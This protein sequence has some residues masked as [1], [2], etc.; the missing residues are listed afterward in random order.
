MVEC[1]KYGHIPMGAQEINLERDF[2]GLLYSK[3]EGLDAIGKAR[4]YKETYA[5]S[6]RVR[7][8]I[9]TLPT[10]EPTKVTFT[11]FFVGDD[12]RAIYNS[13]VSYVT[14]G[15]HC[16]HDDA[17]GKYLYFYVEGE[18][19][20]AEEKWHGSNPYLSLELEVENLFGRTFDAPLD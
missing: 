10:N 2:K 6:D 13:F 14:K 19:K 8:H 17:R 16:Y 7:V 5:D 12:R 4:V 18:V 3:A 20:P 1:D 11:F 9:P 15:F